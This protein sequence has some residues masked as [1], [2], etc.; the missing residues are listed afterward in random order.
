ME[1]KNYLDA[2]LQAFSNS[3]N[4]VF[5][6]I[7]RQYKNDVNA[8]PDIKVFLD[9]IDEFVSNCSLKQLYKASTKL[10]IYCEDH[11]MN[12]ELLALLLEEEVSDPNEV[13]LRQCLYETVRMVVY[14]ELMQSRQKSSTGSILEKLIFFSTLIIPEDPTEEPEQVENPTCCLD[15]CEEQRL[16]ARRKVNVALFLNQKKQFKGKH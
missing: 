2:D 14:I 7:A 9:S 15:E 11:G 8:V 12:P 6:L 4:L 16:I 3:D 10:L 13:E 1:A 5:S